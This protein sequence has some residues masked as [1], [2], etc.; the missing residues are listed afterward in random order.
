MMMVMVMGDTVGLSYLTHS[1]KQRFNRISHHTAQPIVFFEAIGP[2][3]EW[4]SPSRKS[5]SALVAGCFRLGVF[6][7]ATI[8]GRCWALHAAETIPI[9]GP[10][11]CGHAHRGVKYGT[12]VSVLY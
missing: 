5:S 1:A 7:Y 8:T 9:T 10:C 12:M 11:R 2:R 6:V 3:G 4:S